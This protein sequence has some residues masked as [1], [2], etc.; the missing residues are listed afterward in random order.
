MNKLLVNT[1][2]N[3]QIEYNISVLGSR[4]LA[5][6]IDVVIRI[7]YIYIVFELLKNASLAMVLTKILAKP[8]KRS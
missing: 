7:A 1:P 3:V 2:Q 5:F 6:I 4:I 8:V